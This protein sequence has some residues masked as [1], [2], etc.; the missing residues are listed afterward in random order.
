MAGSLQAPNQTPGSAV[1]EGMQRVPRE[2]GAEYSSI[3]GQ[4]MGLTRQSR[5]QM[6]IERCV[7]REQSLG[8]SG[9]I[10]A[11]SA[12]T[13]SKEREIQSAGGIQIAA[14]LETNDRSQKEL[15]RA[16]PVTRHRKCGCAVL[17]Q[18]GP[19]DSP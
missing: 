7:A 14:T 6:F 15:W 9:A 4:I 12:H 1:V 3:R 19:V 8:S 5:R 13:L 10:V 11:S 2:N 16:S 17:P 18:R